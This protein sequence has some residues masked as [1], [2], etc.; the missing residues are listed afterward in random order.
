M[1]PTLVLTTHELKDDLNSRFQRCLYSRE[2]ALEMMNSS[3]RHASVRKYDTLAS[4]GQEGNNCPLLVWT[5][6]FIKLIVSLFNSI[7]LVNHLSN[8]FK[9]LFDPS[10]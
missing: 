4:S 9:S 7:S 2:G 10:R 5:P 6:C 1:I 3:H 8:L